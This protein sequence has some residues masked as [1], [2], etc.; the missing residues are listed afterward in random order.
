MSRLEISITLGIEMQLDFFLNS[1]NNYD[2]INNNDNNNYNDYN[3]YYDNNN[4]NDYGNSGDDCKKS[5]ES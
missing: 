2:N 5:F 1:S 4:N 3:N